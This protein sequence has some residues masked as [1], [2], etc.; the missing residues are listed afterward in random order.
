MLAGKDANA[1][2]TLITSKPNKLSA[3][4]IEKF[5]Q[6]Y[7]AVTI[8]KSHD[9]HDRF[10]ILDNRNVYAFGASLKD[11]GNKCFEVSKIDDMKSFIDYV[12]K[13]INA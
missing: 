8:V 4:A 3:L 11:L 10:I 6:Q 5:E 12:N 2:I 9:F 13:V 7:G 1:T